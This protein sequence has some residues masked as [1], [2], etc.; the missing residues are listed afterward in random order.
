MDEITRR[1]AL[2]VVGV[3]GAALLANSAAANADEKTPGGAYSFLQADQAKSCRLLART[4]DG[5]KAEAKV[6]PGIVNGTYILIVSGKKP[7]LNMQVRLS[8]VTYVRQP[9]YWE[10]EVVGCLTGIGLPAIGAY[11]EHLPLDAVRGTKG[12]EVVWAGGEKERL[13]VPPTA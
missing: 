2:Q 5:T 6:V 9:E 13:P 10:I 7:Y 4:I 11:S 12:I 8:P 3:T 1:R